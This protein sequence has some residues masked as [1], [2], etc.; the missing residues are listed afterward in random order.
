MLKRAISLAQ[1]P[2]LLIAGYKAER[3]TFA[4]PA[5]IDRHIQSGFPILS[6]GERKGG[7][8]RVDDIEGLILQQRF[9]KGSERL[10]RLSTLVAF[11]NLQAIGD[12]DHRH[13]GLSGEKVPQ[14]WNCSG[15]FR[16]KGGRCQA[17]QIRQQ[18]T[19][20]FQ[21]KPLIRA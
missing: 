17:A 15:P 20:F 11:I 3:C 4:A 10:W 1:N 7:I 21:H 16:C 14:G 19:G 6:S 12:P 9:Q 2:S 8:A 18:R 5:T 13:I